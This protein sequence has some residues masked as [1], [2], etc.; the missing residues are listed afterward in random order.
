MLLSI[1]FGQTQ[2]SDPWWNTGHS[3]SD[4]AVMSILIGRIRDKWLLR[5]CFVNMLQAIPLPRRIFIA[6][7]TRMARCDHPVDHRV[8]DSFWSVIKVGE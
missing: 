1:A 7:K 8:L 5:S 3:P 2:E 4:H 6:Q